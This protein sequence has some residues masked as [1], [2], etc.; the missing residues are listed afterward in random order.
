MIR[1]RLAVCL[2]GLILVALA[3]V[4]SSLT[5]PTSDQPPAQKPAPAAF[6]YPTATTEHGQLIY[7]NDLPILIVDGSPKEIGLAVGKLGL[8]AAPRA[9][10]YPRE[11]MATFG[12]DFLWKIVAMA[13]GSG[14]DRENI[15]VGNTLFDLKKIFACSAV[16][17]ESNHSATSGPLLARN[18]D[19]PSLGFLHQYS[20]VTVYRPQ[21]KHAFVSVGFPGLVG[22]LSGMNDAGLSVAI[23][24]VFDAHKGEPIFDMQGV[25]FALCYRKMLEECTTIEEARKVLSGLRR[26]SLTNLVVADRQG[27][28]VF[29]ISPGRVEVRSGE[30][31]MAA[32]TNHFCTPALQRVGGMNPNWSFE[33]YQSL[34]STLDNKT[35]VGPEDLRRQ[36]DTVNMGELTLQTMVFDPK[37]LRLHLAVGKRPASSG[38]LRTIDVGPLL[39]GEVV[40]EKE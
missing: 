34:R 20:L 1:T 32:C 7:R 23:L 6:R 17:V 10:A 33:R 27:I 18:L 19:Y 39:R 30:G 31:G 16:L 4:A 40:Q 2:A 14:V 21:G 29:E 37:N 36:L 22:C 38:T 15:V 11:L 26:T 9:A 25:P 8:K 24:E 35:K 13:E 3:G 5:P 12:A 28:A